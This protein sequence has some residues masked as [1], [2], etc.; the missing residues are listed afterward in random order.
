[1]YLITK[2][3]QGCYHQGIHYAV[4]EARQIELKHDPIAA[5][6]AR[7]IRI[8][9]HNPIVAPPLNVEFHTVENIIRTKSGMCDAVVS[10]LASKLQEAWQIIQFISLQHKS[11]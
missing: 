10:L 6:K 8:K 4:N 7:Q 5:N 11:Y 3:Y 9:T 2:N 1:M